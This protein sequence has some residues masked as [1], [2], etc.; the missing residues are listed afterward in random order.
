MMRNES[1]ESSIQSKRFVIEFKKTVNL[2][3]IWIS[4]VLILSP[5]VNQ[6]N[7]GTEEDALR[8]AAENYGAPLIEPPSTEIT[9]LTMEELRIPCHS[10]SPVTWVRLD[11]EHNLITP[12]TNIEYKI[13]ETSQFLFVATLVFHSVNVDEVTFHYCVQ[14]KS[15]DLA[16]NQADM[17]NEVTNFRAAKTYLFVQDESHPLVPINNPALTVKQ[18][19]P[20][21]IPCKPTSK[22]VEVELYRLDGE[23]SKALQAAKFDE[24]HGFTT[25]FREIHDSGIYICRPKNQD[26]PE[27]ILEISLLPS[28][29]LNF[30]S[31]YF[32]NF[33]T[34]FKCGDLVVGDGK[35]VKNNIHTFNNNHVKK[36]HVNNNNKITWSWWWNQWWKN[37][38]QSTNINFPVKRD[39]KKTK[40]KDDFDPNYR[41][42]PGFDYVDDDND[43][44]DD[45]DDGNNYEKNNTSDSFNNNTAQFNNNNDLITDINSSN[46]N[47]NNV[48]N[49]T[50]DMARTEYITVPIINSTSEG[51]YVNVGGQ[52]KLF[53]NVEIKAGVKYDILWYFRGKQLENSNKYEISGM[54]EQDSN[55]ERPV[56]SRSLTIFNA[57]ERD[58][59]SYKCEVRDHNDNKNDH[60]YLV[61]VL[62][63]TES[64]LEIDSHQTATTS[65][66][67]ATVSLLF[68]F[69]SYPNAT[70]EILKNGH[71]LIMDDRYD[72]NVMYKHQQVIFKMK[73][74][75]VDDTANYTL[76]ADNGMKHMNRTVE[77]FVQ[78]PPIVMLEPEEV[79]SK[80]GQKVILLCQ[81]ISY[82]PSNFEWSYRKCEVDEWDE[83]A[84]ELPGAWVSK[85]LLELYKSLVKLTMSTS[86]SNSTNTNLITNNPIITSNT[87]TTTTLQPPL[88]PPATSK[89]RKSSF[90]TPTFTNTGLD[91]NQQVE[92][93]FK[94]NSMISIQFKI[95][96]AFRNQVPN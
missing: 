52:I 75:H 55:T 2:K 89:I 41:P 88:N 5:H 78:A 69:K 35:S 92:L 85:D 71:R 30:P 27:I 84:R 64:V 13:N 17:D 33:F 86:S 20:Y 44:D 23:D 65:Q 49:S 19:E 93:H 24:K 31:N 80:L 72:L 8:T 9:A 60:V 18:F 40:K 25:R 70:F 6:V 1:K 54:T 16:E 26:E 61:T 42:R 74:V 47:N 63:R 67:N 50:A 28:C 81:S 22:D 3:V 82:P 90:L 95:F 53:C 32:K 46:N 48:T 94:Q 45:V 43:N 36:R 79:Y 91:S 83:C 12:H 73:D 68:N 66:Q 56:G 37:V 77:V 34:H 57:Q 7:A 4:L 11:M 58:S 59:G 10:K 87:L 38:A 14:N 29:E 15:L 76:V 39:I 21:T 62:D 51:G 96:T